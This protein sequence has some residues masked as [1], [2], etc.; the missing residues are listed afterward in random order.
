[1]ESKKAFAITP[2]DM[3]DKMKLEFEDFKSDTKSSRHAINFVLTAHHLKEWIWEYHLKNNKNAMTAISP[4]ITN[5]S[6]YYEFL[7]SECEEIK[8]IRELA[9]NIKHFHSTEDGVIQKTDTHQKTWREITCTWNNWQVPFGYDGLII[10]TKD[11]VWIS[12]LDVFQKVNDYW[13][14]YFLKHLQS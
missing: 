9:N 5:I 4:N 2:H 7:N 6:S 12:V 10:I 3:L 13:V 14:S 1:M 11:K 8:L